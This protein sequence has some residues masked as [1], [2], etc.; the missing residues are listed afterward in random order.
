M[1]DFVE[2]GFDVAL[3]DP[4]IGVHR[5]EPHLSYRIMSPAAG[6]EPV[7]AREEIRLEDRLQ[8]QFQRCLHHPV[9][10]RRD[11]QTAQF[12]AR[13]GDHPLPHR[14]RHETAVLQRGPQ[15]AEE[16]PD[17]R[18][19]HDGRRGTAIHPGSPGTLIPPHLI[20]G[21]QQKRRVSDKAVQ[22]TEPAIE[23]PHRPSGAA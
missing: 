11:P 5:V 7:R 20:P 10:N 4:L 22:I 14:H 1:R 8:H 18:A 21:N 13:L 2:A 12:P 3:D 17:A 19:Q 9:G 23:D 6:T 15:P 16:L